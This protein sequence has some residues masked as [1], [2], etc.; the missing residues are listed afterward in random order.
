MPWWIFRFPR[1]CATKSSPRARPSRTTSCPIRVGSAYFCGE[2]RTWRLRSDCLSGLCNWHWDT[3]RPRQQRASGAPHFSCRSSSLLRFLSAQ[4]AAKLIHSLPDVLAIRWNRAILKAV[5]VA[6]DDSTH[7]WDDLG[8]RGRTLNF[9]GYA[10]A[11]RCLRQVRLGRA[12]LATQM[13]DHFEIEF[14]VRRYGPASCHCSDRW[15]DQ[16]DV[17]AADAFRCDA[18]VG[19]EC[20]NIGVSDFTDAGKASERTHLRAKIEASQFCVG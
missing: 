19:A 14:V 5:G 12:A 4:Q 10:S 13:R 2:P 7:V 20:L 18:H 17:V 3:V 9:K 11:C 1:R 16:I 6:P 15:H 8:I